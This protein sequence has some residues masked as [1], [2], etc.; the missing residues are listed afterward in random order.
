[1]GGA[2]HGK[3]RQWQLPYSFQ[4]AAPLWCGASLLNVKARTWR[5]GVVPCIRHSVEQSSHNSP[6]YLK[7]YKWPALS[8]TK[9]LCNQ[10]N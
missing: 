3:E 5:G 4:H 7:W 10:K 6:I 9:G 8:R 1:M 2:E